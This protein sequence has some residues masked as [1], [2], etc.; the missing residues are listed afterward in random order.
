MIASGSA[1]LIGAGSA[2]VVGCRRPLHQQRL[3]LRDRGSCTAP[4]R[5]RSSSGGGGLNRRS[6]AEPISSRD[7]RPSR[8]EAP[9][10]LGSGPGAGVGACGGGP[11]A[12]ILVRGRRAAGSLLLIADFDAF[13]RELARGLDS[14]ST[15]APPIMPARGRSVLMDEIAHRSLG[16]LPSSV[17]S[18]RLARDAPAIESGAQLPTLADAERPPLCSQR[19]GCLRPGALG[20]VRARTRRAPARLRR[21]Y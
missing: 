13:T 19:V 21:E 17:T 1:E 5:S 16:R 9:E 15:T 18:P 4:G 12:R 11:V 20:V 6:G 10:K 3:R 2:E 7:A 14:S 8:G